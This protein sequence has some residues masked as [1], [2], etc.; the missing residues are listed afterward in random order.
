M[1]T[2][3]ILLMLVLGLGATTAMAAVEDTDG[4]GV[5]S[6]EELKAAYPEITDEAFEEADL[7]ADGAIDAEELAAAEA[8]G[9][10]TAS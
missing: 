2:T 8:A 10:L 9:L 1:K 3:P 7:N 5:Y 6:M 4:D